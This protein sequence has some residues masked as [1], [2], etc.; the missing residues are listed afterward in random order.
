MEQQLGPAWDGCL[1]QKCVIW[2]LVVPLIQFS[3]MRRRHQIMTP[4]LAS[5][6]PSEIQ[7]D[8]LAPAFGLAPPCLLWLFQE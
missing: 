1:T 6:P 3:I 4:M 5:L 8:F 7:V 2:V